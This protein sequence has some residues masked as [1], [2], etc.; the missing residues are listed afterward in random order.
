MR[1]FLGLGGYYRKFVKNF[2]I[3]S[4]PLTTVLKKGEMFVW[5]E[6]HEEAFQALKE[7]LILTPVLAL[8]DFSK[9]FVLETDA[10]EKGV[11]AVLQ[12]NGH[13]IA[14]ISKALGPKNQMLS[15]Y[16]KECLAMLMAVHHWR[17]YLM[18]SEFIIKTNQLSLIHLDDQRLSTPWQQKA[19]T[20]LI[21]LQYKLCYRKGADNKAADA[22][23]RIHPQNN[24]E[25]LGMSI[26]Q[27]IWLEELINSYHK[28]R[29]TA[30]LLSA[31]A[32]KSPSGDYLLHDGVIKYKGRIL[33]H[34]DPAM[35]TRLISALH[36]SPVGGHSGY[37][38]TY[39]R[40]K[41]LFSWPKMKKGVKELVASCQVCQQAKSERVKYPG[42]LQPLP[43]PQFAWQVV[44]SH[45]YNCILVVVD[46]F[47]K[48]AH[49]VPLS[50][51]FTA[52][53]VAMAYME[54]IYKLHGLPEAIV[55]DRDK[56]FTSTLWQELFRLTGTELRMSSAYHPQSDG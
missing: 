46:K 53:K 18:Q 37:H 25:I 28:F 47:S 4:K 19:L 30:K 9:T 7:A 40:V 52:L 39:H 33:I 32:V 11:G 38:V 35:H 41:K 42:L 3:I 44:T 23:S 15:T 1:G 34:N 36:C 49:F 13:P 45:S 2:G 8:L 43:V 17:P 14:Y 55:S 10:S 51:P 54:H 50:H 48:Y 24:L 20:K 56:I 29:E 6:W 27:P 22:L 26:A 12:Q 16:E 21:G 5:T 31:L